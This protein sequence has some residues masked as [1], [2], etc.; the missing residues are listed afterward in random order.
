MFIRRFSTQ[1]IPLNQVRNRT[2]GSIFSFMATQGT[3]RHSGVAKLLYNTGLLYY[4]L[5][6]TQGN[7]I[8]TFIYSSFHNTKYSWFLTYGLFTLQLTCALIFVLSMGFSEDLQNENCVLGIFEP[9]FHL[10]FFSLCACINIKILL[11]Y[12]E[13][14][15][16]TTLLDTMLYY[17]CIYN[18]TNTLQLILRILLSKWMKLTLKQD[19]Y[20][21]QANFFFQSQC[22]Q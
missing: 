17:D 4:W 16:L 20:E 6:T 15:F 9:R 14:I 18:P 8:H 13:C 11:C 21:N 22:L 2:A 10:Q 7:T 3:W 5:Q 12:W 19:V 1:Y